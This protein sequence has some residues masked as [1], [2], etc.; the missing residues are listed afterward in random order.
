[1]DEFKP[2][3][4]KGKMGNLFGLYNHFRDA[5]DGNKGIRGKPDQTCT[6]Y[7]LLAPIAV[8]GEESADESAIRERSIELL[9]SKRD[10]K[11]T[12]YQASFLWLSANEIVV[13]SFGRSL[14]DTALRTTAKEVASW[15]SEGYNYFSADLPS[16]V[17]TNLCSMYAGLCLINKF[18]SV[19]SV[20]FNSA[21]PFDNEECAKYLETAAREYLLDDSS[22]NK[23]IIESTLE[24]MSRMK[25]KQGEDFAFENNNQAGKYRKPT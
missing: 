13:R 8:A 20:P 17:N 16:R 15:H 6:F 11:N 23:G 1:M 14:L 25:L 10:L 9:F 12:D 21:F 19:L 4:L 22:Y 2:S 5:Y 7:D 18:C 24:V 3:K